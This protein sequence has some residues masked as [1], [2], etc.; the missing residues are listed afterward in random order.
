[1]NCTRINPNIEV[2][3]YLINDSDIEYLI[4]C[5]KTAILIHI[6]YMLYFFRNEVAANLHYVFEILIDFWFCFVEILFLFWLLY[7]AMDIFVK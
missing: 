6:C 2:H 3:Y 7:L 4:I 1:M 5:I